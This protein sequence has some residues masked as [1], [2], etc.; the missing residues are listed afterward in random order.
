[1]SGAR[2][3]VSRDD[4]E[5]SLRRLQRELGGD[6]ARVRP[7]LVTLSR[8]LAVGLVV[9]AYVVGRRVGR[10]KSAVVEIRRI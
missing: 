8:A 7:Q 5:Q 1:M 9:V 4:I 6:V 3:E 2:L 10:R